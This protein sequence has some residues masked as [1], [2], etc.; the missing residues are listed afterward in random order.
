MQ[1]GMMPG[2]L[3]QIMVNIAVGKIKTS[4]EGAS[5]SDITIYD[6]FMGLGTTAM[7]ANSM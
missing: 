2:K 5:R 6:P 7:I 3:T 4:T 1:I